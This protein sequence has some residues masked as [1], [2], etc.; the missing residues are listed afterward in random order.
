LALVRLGRD[1]DA[2]VALRR[3][4]ELTPE[5]VRYAYVFAVALY[6][7]GEVEPALDVLRAAHEN[8]PSDLE[9]LQALASIGREAGHDEEALG[10]LRKLQALTQSRPDQL[11]PRSGARSRTAQ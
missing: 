6:S 8:H 5:N 1:A 4:A 7:G 2:S 9:I 3:A 11:P 10:Y